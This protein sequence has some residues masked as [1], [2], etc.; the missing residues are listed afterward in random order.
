MLR[1]SGMEAGVEGFFIREAFKWSKPCKAKQ[2]TYS[3]YNALAVWKES[4]KAE[5]I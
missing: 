5:N 2:S 3:T 1:V 4:I